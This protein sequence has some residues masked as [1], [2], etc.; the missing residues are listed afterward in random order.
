MTTASEAVIIE[1][2]LLCKRDVRVMLPPVGGKLASQALQPQVRTTFNCLSG[3]GEDLLRP[4]IRSALN[5]LNLYYLD[6]SS[7]VRRCRSRCRN[8]SNVNCCVIQSLI[9][10]SACTTYIFALIRNK[11]SVLP[12]RIYTFPQ[13]NFVRPV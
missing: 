10:V 2:D 7:E 8:G 3:F 4:S 11:S 6:P 9:N 1:G 12:P 13:V 5:H